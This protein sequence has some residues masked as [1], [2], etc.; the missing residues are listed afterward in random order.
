MRAETLALIAAVSLAGCA[1]S[2]PKVVVAPAPV[3][4]PLDASYDWHVLL[5]APFGSVLKDIPLTLH[6]VLLF[7][8]AKSASSGEEAE[9]FAVDGEVPRF[10]DRS[11]DEYMLCFT[12]DRLSR[13]QVVV[14]LPEDQSA[15]IFADACGLWMK[16][17]NAPSSNLCEGSEA[18]VAFSGRLEDDPEHA[19]SLLTVELAAPDER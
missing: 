18:A 15:K 11:P 8:E 5:V 19:D 9:C 1:A 2:T 14:R 16:R 6:E 3:K 13:I 12:H 10:V 7:H 17:A 4:V